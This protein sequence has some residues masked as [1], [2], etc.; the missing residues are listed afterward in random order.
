MLAMF[1]RKEAACVAI[2]DVGVEG[3]RKRDG[4]Y[5]PFRALSVTMAERECVCAAYQ[6][7]RIHARKGDCDTLLLLPIRAR[8]KC[9]HVLFA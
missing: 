2:G 5:S 9:S 3:R 8:S 7:W 1:D 6:M 4:G